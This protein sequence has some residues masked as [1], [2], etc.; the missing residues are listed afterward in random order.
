ME[1]VFIGLW[2]TVTTP[3]DLNK[4]GQLS[5]SKSK[6]VRLSRLGCGINGIHL[7]QRL[8]KMHTGSCGRHDQLG[9]KFDLSRLP[10]FGKLFDKF[11]NSSVASGL[12]LQNASFIVICEE[13]P[14]YVISSNDV[15]VRFVDVFAGQVNLQ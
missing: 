9:T 14:I 12:D 5:L 2:N 8:W 7:D 10:L 11:L 4:F 6:I 15:P 1:K 3:V 13:R